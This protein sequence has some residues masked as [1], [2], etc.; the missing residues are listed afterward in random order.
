MR[1]RF[2]R[3]SKYLPLKIRIWATAARAIYH[4][5]EMPFFATLKLVG[6]SWYVFC[7]I[8]HLQVNKHIT[9]IEFEH[10]YKTLNMALIGLKTCYYIPTNQPTSPDSPDPFCLHFSIR[11]YC[12]VTMKLGQGCFSWVIY[13]LLTFFNCSPLPR[14]EHPPL[15]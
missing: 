12:S 3:N 5:T 1:L 11:K 6:V 15:V 10:F 9:K 14:K 8:V 2:P 13:F 7:I 4:G